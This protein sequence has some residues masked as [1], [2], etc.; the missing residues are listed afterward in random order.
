ME[1]DITKLFKRDPIEERFD[2][3]KISTKVFRV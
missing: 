1:K 2:K 3:I